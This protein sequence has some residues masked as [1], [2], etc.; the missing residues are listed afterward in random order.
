MA[1]KVLSRLRRLQAQALS[2][3]DD[4]R[5]SL[6]SEKELPWLH[7]F[8]HFWVMVG[9]S[10]LR[11]RCPVRASALAYTTLLA[12]VPLLAIGISISTSLLKR[13]GGDQQIERFINGF[14]AKVAPQLDLVTKADADD[15][16]GRQK[17]VKSIQ[18]YIKN[19]SSGKLAATAIIAGVVER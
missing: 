16:D 9:K 10:F 5:F 17:V 19:V 18:D 4:E 7:R 11:N 14:V 8:A 13:E 2:V 12:L 1:E 15:T 6:F 3:F